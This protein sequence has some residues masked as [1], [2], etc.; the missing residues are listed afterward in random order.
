ML[1][2]LGGVFGLGLAFG[3]LRLLVAIGPATLPR[4]NEI[5]ID[6]LVLSFAVIASLLSGLLFGLI[7]VA[8]HAGPHMLA[9]RSGGRTSSQSRERHRARNT[10]VVVQVALAMVL[11]VASGLMIRTFLA[12]RDVQP[13]VTEPDHVQMIRIAIPGAQVA[14]P[15]RVFRKRSHCAPHAGHR[16]SV[17]SPNRPLR[18]STPRSV[19]SAPWGT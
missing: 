6:P 11:L 4:L 10:L 17:T 14:D 13:G 12:L 8:R 2:L 7:P 5:T 19:T 3:A 9:L 18:R 1:G 16:C 15:E